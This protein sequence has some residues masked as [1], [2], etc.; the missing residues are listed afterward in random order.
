MNV[1][2]YINVY[3]HQILDLLSNTISIYIVKIKS[4]IFRTIYH[5]S[6]YNLFPFLRDWFLVY[7]LVVKRDCLK[8][9]L[10]GLVYVL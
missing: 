9:L 4:P 2:S 5:I 1:I 7:L 10:N 3:T 6:G 8:V